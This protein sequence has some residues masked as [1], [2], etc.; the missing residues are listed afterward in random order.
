MD[1]DVYSRLFSIGRQVK[2]KT[3]SCKN[4]VK[5]FTGPPA[6]ARAHVLGLNRGVGA[7]TH[8]YSNEDLA[9]E[10]C[11]ARAEKMRSDVQI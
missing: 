9:S 4:C 7:C 11:A 5:N 2:N 6:R 10:L 3:W 8:S 1:E